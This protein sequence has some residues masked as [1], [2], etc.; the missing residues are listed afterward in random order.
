[1]KHLLFPLILAATLHAQTFSHIILMIQE[2]RTPDNLFGSST[3]PGADLV[4]PSGL[5]RHMYDYPDLMHDH[6]Y[7]LKEAAG[8]YP[9]RAYYY[10][11]A[12]QVAPYVQLATQFGW[13]NRM[14]QTNQGPSAAAHQFLFRGTSSITADQSQKFA[15]ENWTGGCLSAIAQV[16]LIDP[17]TGVESGTAW[18]CFA[19]VP[20]LSGE[21][22]QA[23]LTW[24]YYTPNPGNMWT[25][26]NSLMDICV[27][28]KKK[29]AVNTC[30]G[31]DFEN[32]VSPQT[33]ILSD[34]QTGRL[35]SLSWVIPSQLCSDHLTDS[36]GC[37]PSWVA[38]VVNA[39]GSSQYWQNTLIL[40]TWDDW[41]GFWD[42]VPPPINDSGWCEAYCYGFRVPLLVI[43][44]LT[45]PG[46]VSNAPMD[47]NSL[48]AFTA[49]NFGV[50]RLPYPALGEFDPGFFAGEARPFQAIKARPL[51]RKEWL[52]RGD[53]DNE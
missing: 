18:T 1:M 11:L 40:V 10:V 25:A 22:E 32:V 33:Q 17:N 42:H 39:I 14:F 37:G 46:Y 21:L 19:G 23:G 38:S 16:K 45:P 44:A 13:A 34:I 43:S 2:N 12:S 9:T 26:P 3:I 49:D 31:P 30:S 51:T 52:D 8:S 50:A 53:P 41:G 24:R 28:V 20:T 47:F 5:G 36:N 27:P 7:F 35:A 29:L 4:L 48:L 15:A 6:A